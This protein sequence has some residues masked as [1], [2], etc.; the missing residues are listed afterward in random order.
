MNILLEL[1]D[2][3][4]IFIGKIYENINKQWDKMWKTV[5]DMK[6]EMELLMKIQTKGNLEMKSIGSWTETS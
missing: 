4:N 6:V 2:H 1:K 5:Q 3:V